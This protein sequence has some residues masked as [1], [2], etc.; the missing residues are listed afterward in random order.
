MSSAGILSGTPAAI[1]SAIVPPPPVSATYTVTAAN[2]SGSTTAP[3]TITIY[4]ARQSVPNVAQQIT[5]L[6]IKNSSFQFLDTG[7]VVTDP[8]DVRVPPVEWLAGQASSSVV[9]PD[10]NT[11][12][13]LTSGFNR[14][15]QDAF[16]F[17]RPGVF[18][19]ACIHLRHSF[20]RARL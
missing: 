18:E 5:P 1:P 9:S 16:P 11:L 2:A 3:L 17:L 7:V 15:Y 10:G 4:N 19:R 13:V 12:L 20:R 6:A 8:I 14:V